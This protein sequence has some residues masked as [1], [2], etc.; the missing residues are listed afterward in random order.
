MG[1][2]WREAEI[3]KGHADLLELG[4][5]RYDGPN[6]TSLRSKWGTYTFPSFEWPIDEQFFPRCLFNLETAVVLF[7]GDHS[8]IIVR[9]SPSEAV[10]EESDVL[11]RSEDDD[12]RFMSIERLADSRL[13]FLYE[14]GILLVDGFGRTT[15]HRLH[16]DISARLLDVTTDAVTIES[17]WPSELAGNRLSYRLRDGSEV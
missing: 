2:A 5:L 11:V 16:Q 8:S 10:C 3:S 15:W 6:A 12:L 7:L 4:E 9:C 1:L 14:L 17:Q 13:L